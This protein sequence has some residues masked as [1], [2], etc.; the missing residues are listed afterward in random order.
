MQAAHSPTHTR[1]PCHH[2]GALPRGCTVP[3]DWRASRPTAPHAIPCLFPLPSPTPPSAA[4]HQG[5]SLATHARLDPA[6][7]PLPLRVR[8]RAG[9]M[10]I[11]HRDCLAPSP[12]PPHA[13]LRKFRGWPLRY[14]HHKLE[15]QPDLD[16]CGGR[17]GQRG[18]QWHAELWLPLYRLR[19]QHTARVRGYHRRLER[20]LLLRHGRAR[21]WWAG[22]RVV[23]LPLSV[24]YCG[25]TGC[26]QR[27]HTGLCC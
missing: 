6:G 26:R 12:F 27:R 13:L 25:R 2:Q 5:C 19:C 14:I 16:V 3:A 10:S 24:G 17:V 23:L 15:P 11:A 7:G 4:P 1:F 20:E 21:H 8:R 22:C 18:L 9:I